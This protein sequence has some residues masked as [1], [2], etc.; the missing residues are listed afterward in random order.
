VPTSPET[1]VAH[2][3][4]LFLKKE[5]KSPKDALSLLGE[6]AEGGADGVSPEDL[7]ELIG[8][9]S[10]AQFSKGDISGAKDTLHTGLKLLLS[11]ERGFELGKCLTWLLIA[12]IQD[13]TYE[14]GL[15]HG[16]RAYE[17]LRNESNPTDL[18]LLQYH[19]GRALILLGTFKEARYHLEDAR[20]AFRRLKDYGNAARAMNQLARLA[21]MER[22][23]K[24]AFERLETA[25]DYAKR[26][27]KDEDARAFTRNLGTMYLR[28]GD[29]AL[30]REAFESAG[31]EDGTGGRSEA[32][33]RISLGNLHL[34][35]RNWDE[36]RSHLQR[37]LDISASGD[38]K[39]ELSKG[40]ELLGQTSFD[41][42]DIEEAAAHYG[43]ARA[44]AEEIAPESALMMQIQSKMGLLLLAQGRLDD[45]GV[46]CKEALRLSDSLNDDIEK[47]IAQRTLG[48]IELA[49]D[50]RP[51][52]LDLL[53][54]SVATLES[55]DERVER[56]RSLMEV[57]VILG[58][59]AKTR[60]DALKAAEAA[61]RLLIPVGSPYWSAL[62]KI[63]LADIEL[64]L[65]HTDRAQTLLSDSYELLRGTD[66]TAALE[67]FK[68]V[69][70]R[71]N[72]V[73]AH[74]ASETSEE[75]QLVATWG[76]ESQNGF[77]RF[78]KEVIR[79]TGAKRGIIALRGGDVPNGGSEIIENFRRTEARKL[80]Q[81]LLSGDR[82]GPLTREGQ[83]VVSTGLPS[84]NGTRW[85]FAA[86]PLMVNDEF[87]G[88][89][90]IDKG[91]SVHEAF[92]QREL[93]LLAIHAGALSLKIVGMKG[94]Q[95]LQDN[96]ELMKELAKKIEF[97]NI[98]TRSKKVLENIQLI[99][100]IKD[101]PIPV[102][103]EGETGTGK[104]LLALA[105]HYNSH[106]REKKFVAVNCAAIPKELVES[107][108]FGHEKGAFT[109]A[110][111]QKIGKFE[112]A[113]GGTLFL[114]EVS[115][116]D[117]FVQAK[118]LRVVEKGEFERVGG[119]DTLRV[120]V[121]VVAATNRDIEGD[122]ES[123]KFRPDLFYRLGAVRMLL[124]PLKERPEDIPIL[125][126]HFLDKYRARAKAK[127]F[128]AEAM[129]HMMDY[130]WPG[131]VRELENEIRRCI[132]ISGRSRSI[133]VDILSPRLV[134]RAKTV[135][136]IQ[137]NSLKEAVQRTELELIKKALA[138]YNW[139]KAEVTRQLGIS[140]PTLLHKIKAYGL[141]K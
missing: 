45:A 13:G 62:A 19:M 123:M 122:V 6:A 84:S 48:L 74:V 138:E 107:E 17:I 51:E 29:W 56:A 120:D 66:E 87:Q 55:I 32:L 125:V 41:Q 7:F 140:Y 22:K 3:I 11:T 2:R 71:V 26:A 114:D 109:G 38:M 111:R 113:D 121:R 134:Q 23:W 47:G 101:S 91:P 103:I 8:Y 112:L 70:G 35:L 75:F 67:A 37:A 42:G 141:E 85:S 78:L 14:E 1:T 68:E 43:D 136:R 65:S 21:F 39:R 58:A 98:V 92:H 93:N 126:E 64:E 97:S 15:E 108:L 110:Y 52:A 127:T 28:Y 79:K 33:R 83:M 53:N 54:R 36:A 59:D 116:M 9:L 115:E 61:H 102:L 139:N 89:I 34:Y 104:E 30:A 73:M 40:H 31:S 119:I 44:I 100:S 12:S 77:D 10:K 129:R 18:A 117:P 86:A 81:N 20:T 106:R 124:P 76:P 63:R 80:V 24:L 96:L 118:L 57:A 99:D 132:A 137:G 5:K 16:K 72:R 60:T 25:I 69:Q 135:T 128:T 4:C 49:Q 27:G 90:Y 46:A 95:L 82:V 105:I 131:N 130:D 88:L 50:R 133:G 94:S